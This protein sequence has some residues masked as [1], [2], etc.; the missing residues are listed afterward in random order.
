MSFWE[1]KDFGK[2]SQTTSQ[3]LFF[4]KQQESWDF[5]EPK[6]RQFW[7]KLFCSI[8]NDLEINFIF[9]FW[10]EK[11]WNLTWNCCKSLTVFS[12]KQLTSW[13]ERLDASWDVKS[14][15]KGSAAYSSQQSQDSLTFSLNCSQSTHI[16]F[17]RNQSWGAKNNKKYSSTFSMSSSGTNKDETWPLCDAERTWSCLKKASGKITVQKLL[18]SCCWKDL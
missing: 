7:R 9:S 4:N 17:Q 16:N 15:P 8:S 10:L 2:S 1:Q 3:L 18:T 6:N 13:C 14:C 11:A 12:W 5:L